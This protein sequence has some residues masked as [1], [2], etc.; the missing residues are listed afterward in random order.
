MRL[1]GAFMTLC[2]LVACGDGGQASLATPKL[3]YNGSIPFPAVV[4]EAIVLTPAVSGTVDQY[5]VSPSLPS[6]LSID[7]LSGVI[8]GTPTKASG[9][10]TYVVS[11]TGAGV[12]IT[13]PLVLS[14]TEPPNSLS[15][16]SPVSATVGA[17]LAPLSP[18]IAGTVEHYAVSPTLP[19][20]ILLDSASGILS[21]TPSEARNLAPYT[22]TANSLAG[23]TRFILLLTVTPA[24]PGAMPK[25]GPAHR[26]GF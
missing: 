3:S 2:A 11:A 26:T 21:G 17:P 22:I 15:Y 4:G 23:N 16:V 10:A 14:V 13:F 5:R 6:G 8:S 19:P 20:G 25:H 24:P 18:S 1:T 7:E 12:R 9:P